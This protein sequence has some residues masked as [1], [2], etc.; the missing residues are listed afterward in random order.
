VTGAMLAEL[1]RW[2][3]RT[4]RT[5]V[6]LPWRAW[7]RVLAA[8]RSR[9][10]AAP[11]APAMLLALAPPSLQRRF[12]LAVVRLEPRIQLSIRTFSTSSR[13][14]VVR[15]LVGTRP[16]SDAAAF[17]VVGELYET[18]VRRLITERR[19]IELPVRHPAEAAVSHGAAVAGRLAQAVSS[20]AP[21]SLSDRLWQARSPELA[22]PVPPPVAPNRGGDAVAADVSQASPGVAPV[23]AQPAVPSVDLERLTDQVVRQIDRRIVAHRERVGRI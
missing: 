13:S 19:R 12:D 15:P 20:P 6:E 18:A 16:R 9:L 1:L 21:A 23:A 10:A 4:R 22:L 5:A 8:R 2:T 14:T 3:R 17:S 7:A 11:P